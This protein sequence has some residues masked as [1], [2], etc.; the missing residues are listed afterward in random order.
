MSIDKPSFASQ[1]KQP[2]HK[3]PNMIDAG[4]SP[5]GSESAILKPSDDMHTAKPTPGNEAP[6]QVSKM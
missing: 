3:A 5:D 2:L 4:K 6:G 1:E